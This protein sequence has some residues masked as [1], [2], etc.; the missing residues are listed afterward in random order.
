[1]RLPWIA[2]ALTA[3]AYAITHAFASN[4]PA[5]ACNPEIQLKEFF[6]TASCD[7]T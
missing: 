6:A 4:A 1:M 2:L 7:L 3:A 5:L